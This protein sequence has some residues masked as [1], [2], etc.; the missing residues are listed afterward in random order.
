MVLRGPL[1]CVFCPSDT[2]GHL[3]GGMRG[4]L[5]DAIRF[6]FIGACCN[7]ETEHVCILFHFSVCS[8]YQSFIPC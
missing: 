5:G 6:S 1:G 2:F 3:R 7:F 8:N 4:A